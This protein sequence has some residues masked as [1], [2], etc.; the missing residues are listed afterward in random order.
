MNITSMFINKRPLKQALNSIIFL[1][2]NIY[3]IND[4]FFIVSSMKIDLSVFNVNN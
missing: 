4:T 3:S 2:M 1:G